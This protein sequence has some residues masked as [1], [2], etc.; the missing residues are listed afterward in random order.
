MA[1]AKTIKRFLEWIGLKEKLHISVHQPPLFKESEIWWCHLGE[2]IGIEANGKGD[3]FTRPVFVLKK[4][5]RYSFLGLPLTTKLK[6]GSWYAPIGFAGVK[7]VIMLSQGRVLDY[8]RLKE[9][10]GELE[11]KE[12]TTVK[13]AYLK[14]HSASIKK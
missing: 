14:L 4:Y 6:E 3:K 9:K 5:D 10:M 2:N 8:R 11:E 1:F 13:D 12:A 7:Q